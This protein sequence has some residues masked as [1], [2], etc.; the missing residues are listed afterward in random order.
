MNDSQVKMKISLTITFSLKHLWK[1]KSKQS[2]DVTVVVIEWTAFCVTQ[3]DIQKAGNYIVGSRFQI[4]L[5]PPNSA[6]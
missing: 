2:L 3:F 4:L 1:L 6:L 5:D